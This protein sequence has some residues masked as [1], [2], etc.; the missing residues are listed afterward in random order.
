MKRNPESPWNPLKPCNV[1]P[2]E[3]EEQVLSWLKILSDDLNS[4]SVGHLKH[5]S[6]SGGDYEFDE[7]AEFIILNGAIIIVLIEC[8]RYSRPVEREKILSLYAK[9]QDVGAH[10]AIIFSTSGF[11]SGALSYAKDRGIACLT[12]VDGDF[13]YETK[14]VKGDHKPPPWA[15]IPRYAAILVE[16][17]N[18]S[19]HCSTISNNG[20]DS[21]RDWLKL[22]ER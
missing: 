3:F 7:V 10:K 13:L 22:S 17:E 6:G 16:K 8:K 18:K 20:I 5:L 19:I 15:N 14:D 21:L 12:F 1:T 2:K 4:F 9:L 11:Q